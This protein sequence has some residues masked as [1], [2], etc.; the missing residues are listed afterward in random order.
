M[1][2]QNGSHFDL[3]CLLVSAEDAMGRTT[4]ALARGILL[5]GV[6]CPRGLK[7]G[8]GRGTISTLKLAYVYYCV[9]V[10]GRL[11]L[12]SGLDLYHLLFFLRVVIMQ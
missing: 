2:A 10:V 3:L 5:V 8:L 12:L 11:S 9:P 4:L 1:L 7:D 6:P